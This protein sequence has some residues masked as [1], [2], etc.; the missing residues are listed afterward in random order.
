MAR[1]ALAARCSGA[2][3]GLPQSLAPV[4]GRG[5][6]ITDF[7][8][9]PRSRVEAASRKDEVGND[10][11][12]LTAY[13]NGSGRSTPFA[14]ALPHFTFVANNHHGAPVFDEIIGTLLTQTLNHARIKIPLD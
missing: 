14:I 9:T 1:H 12:A 6:A 5:S 2:K 8:R 7:F 11:L 3:S 13:R 4:F 10:S